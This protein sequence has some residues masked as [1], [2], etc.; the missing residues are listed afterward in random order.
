MTKK[1]KLDNKEKI[2]LDRKER[3]KQMMSQYEKRLERAKKI[4]LQYEKKIE[5]EYQYM[6]EIG[7]LVGFI[8]DNENAHMVQDKIYREFIK[9]ICSNKFKSMDEIKKIALL[10]KEEVV[11]RDI[12][13]W[14][15]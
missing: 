13:R 3:I 15:S 12:G 2:Q 1:I 10:L 5:L 7:E 6:K 11:K 8:Y 9:D 4:K 14:Y